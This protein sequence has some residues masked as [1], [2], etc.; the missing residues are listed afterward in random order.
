MVNTTRLHYLCTRVSGSLVSDL[1]KPTV[2][3]GTFNPRPCTISAI[4]GLLNFFY[5]KWPHSL[6]WACLRA[7]CG[8]V[9]VSGIPNRQNYCV[10]FAVYTWLTNV[11]RVGDPC[12]ILEA[13]I[14]NLT[15]L[16]L[17]TEVWPSGYHKII[18]L[19][20]MTVW[21]GAHSL[22]KSDPQVIIKSFVMTV[23]MGAHSLRC[24]H[25]CTRKSALP[26]SQARLRMLTHCLIRYFAG[27]GVGGAC[28][29]DGTALV[30]VHCFR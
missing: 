13:L 16:T 24:W 4:H 30:M 25:A 10:V 20:L 23:W 15:F 7:A 26:A 14:T 19:W 18:C 29:F 5:G 22:C 21:M 11:P 28:N 1:G 9:T 12:F 8:E 6:S 2:T 3:L 17:V 27:Y